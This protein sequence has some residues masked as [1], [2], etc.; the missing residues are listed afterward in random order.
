[1]SFK[2]NSFVNSS[3]SKIPYPLKY[4]SIITDLGKERIKKIL[5]LSQSKGKIVSIITFKDAASKGM[6]LQFTKAPRLR[7]D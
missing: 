1:L 7:E 3:K 4:P 6:V 5:N 2:Q